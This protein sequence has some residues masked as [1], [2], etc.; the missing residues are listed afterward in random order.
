MVMRENNLSVKD[1]N[2]DS[3]TLDSKLQEENMELKKEVEVLRS[4]LES[5]AAEHD[6]QI[7]DLEVALNELQGTYDS[8]LESFRCEKISLKAELESKRI[9]YNSKLK[10][11]NALLAVTKK[12][13]QSNLDELSE[14]NEQLKR[15]NE[16][17]QGIEK[18]N[19]ELEIS[20]VQDRIS[21]GFLS[22]AK[23]SLGDLTASAYTKFFSLFTK[24][25]AAVATASLVF[26]GLLVAGVAYATGYHTEILQ[27]MNHYFK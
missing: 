16:R 11:F 18:Q 9:I 4:E 21:P 8:N 7:K 22:G 19:F 23:S 2:Q 6:A 3:Y 13:Y 5:Q 10:L 17:L 25:N 15:E 1:V 14:E 27:S 20:T 26:G 12:R 24:E